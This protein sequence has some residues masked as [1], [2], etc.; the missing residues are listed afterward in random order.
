MQN[1]LDDIYANV[2]IVASLPRHPSQRLRCRTDQLLDVESRILSSL[3]R[4]MTGDSRERVLAAVD[5]TLDVISNV[6]EMAE[7]LRGMGSVWQNRLQTF[8]DNVASHA[9]LFCKGLT[10]LAATHYHEDV[11]T[12]LRLSRQLDRFLSIVATST[13]KKPVVGLEPEEEE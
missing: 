2:H 12:S 6:C 9:N 11:A 4:K 10:T 5:H 1:I 8:L 3:Q 13:Q 7:A